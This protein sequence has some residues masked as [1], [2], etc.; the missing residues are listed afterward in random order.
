MTVAESSIILPFA[1]HSKSNVGKIY[2]NYGISLFST[3]GTPGPSKAAFLRAVR[4]NPNDLQSWVGLCISIR[5]ELARSYNKLGEDDMMKKVSQLENLLF[6]ITNTARTQLQEAQ[7][8]ME[9]SKVFD[10]EKLL[11]WVPLMLSDCKYFQSKLT[12]DK[13]TKESLLKESYALAEQ[14]LVQS[15][16]RKLQ[17]SCLLIMARCLLLNS[18]L[19]GSVDA[20]KKVIQ[21]DPNSVV[22]EVHIIFFTCNINICSFFYNRN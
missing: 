15:N 8:L 11:K 6:F 13:N 5:S 17:S 19:A 2:V 9:K 20:F 22:W 21:L 12:E 3:G 4:A 1:S 14:I 18:D 10:M 16:E 7:R